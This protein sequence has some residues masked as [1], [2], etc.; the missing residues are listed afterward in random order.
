VNKK[1][2]SVSSAER[3][4]SIRTLLPMRNGMSDKNRASVIG[5]LHRE[6]ADHYVLVTKTKFYHW[7]VEGPE[8][9]DI[10]E[11]LDEH[12]EILSE[13]IDEIAEQCLKLG[14]QSVGTLEWFKAHTR[15]AEDPG[16][17]IPDTRQMLQNLLDGHETI[18]ENLHQEIGDLDEKFDDA[19][20]SNLLQD[21]SDK[22]HKMAWMLR[23]MLQKS[24]IDAYAVGAVGDGATNGATNGNGSAKS[25]GN[26][27]ASRG[28][29]S[30]RGS[31][32]RK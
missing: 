1:S 28:R 11:L 17:S 24:M 21:I 27:T 8:F 19:V 15:L 22:H 6:V 9:H 30:S 14:G 5:V 25:T 26:K 2:V 23:M 12:Y 32:S 18:M 29:G 4:K 20:T 16:E 7:N 10:H 13:Q 31:S 3:T